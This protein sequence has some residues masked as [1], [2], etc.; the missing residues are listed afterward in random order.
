MKLAQIFMD[1]L[2]NEWCFY[3]EKTERHTEEVTQRW[4]Q[5]SERCIDNTRNV[6]DYQQPPEIRRQTWGRFSLRA[7]RRNQSFRCLDLKFLV[8]PELKKLI[9]V[10]LSHQVCGNL[11]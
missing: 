5:R 6:K 3:K 10:V 9:S 1:S 8:S 7:S 11:L 2:S 4:R